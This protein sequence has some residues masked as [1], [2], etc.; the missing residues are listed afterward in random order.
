MVPS[1]L[2]SGCKRLGGCSDI[3]VVI[4]MNEEAFGGLAMTAEGLKDFINPKKEGNE[5]NESLFF[6][7]VI[8]RVRRTGEYVHVRYKEPR[9]SDD[10]IPEY[11]QIGDNGMVL[12]E[13][14]YKEME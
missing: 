10:E 3:I 7:C 9:F 11:V 12:R 14:D 13:F 1:C 6:G 4:I 8:K 2:V 5:G